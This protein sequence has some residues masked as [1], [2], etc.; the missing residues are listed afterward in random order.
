MASETA[1]GESPDGNKRGFGISAGQILL[2]TGIVLSA[3]LI[4]SGVF[5]LKRKRDADR[6]MMEERRMRRRERLKEIGC[7]QEEFERMLE[8]RT[9]R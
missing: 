1:E 3:V 6:R 9:R 5:L 8:E 2:G 7:S 4:G